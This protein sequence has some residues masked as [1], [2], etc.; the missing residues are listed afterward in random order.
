MK[1]LI[2]DTETTNL[3]STIA[4]PLHKQ[5]RIIEFFGLVWDDSTDQ[6]EAHSWLVNPGIPIPQKVTEITGITDAMVKDAPSFLLLMP[7]I[8]A[9]FHSVDRMVAH[10]LSYD[11]T[12]VEFELQRYA[13]SV[14]F[15]EGLCTVEV[16]E[17]LKG[18]RLSLSALYEELFGETFAGAHRAEQDVRA[19]ARCYRELI[20]RGEI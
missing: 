13:G 5:P 3:I 14:N 18:H 15:P 8:V 12:I 2:F 19:L 16:T 10:N 7:R 4:R 20:K 6:E 11:K 1:H 17:S 9:L